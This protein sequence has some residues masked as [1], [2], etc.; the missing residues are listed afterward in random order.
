M[1]KEVLLEINRFRQISGLINESK[2][3]GVGFVVDLLDESPTIFRGLTNDQLNASLESLRLRFPDNKVI[4]SMTPETF[5]N[6]WKGLDN[7]MKSFIVKGLLDEGI[8]VID[9]LVVKSIGDIIKLEPRQIRYKMFDYEKFTDFMNY[10]EDKGIEIGDTTV[11]NSLERTFLSLRKTKVLSKQEYKMLLKQIENYNPMKFIGDVRDAFR[12]TRDV[13]ETRIIKLSNEFQ[14]KVRTNPGMKPEQLEELQ[15]V[16]SAA[17]SRELNKIEIMANEAAA[18]VFLK[19]DIDPKLKDIIENSP[20][21]FFEDFRKLRDADI[22]NIGVAINE[23]FSKFGKAINPFTR[24]TNG[25]LRLKLPKEVSSDFIQFFSTGQWAKFS[26]VYRY[27]VKTSAAESG[28]KKATYYATLLINSYKG[29]FMAHAAYIMLFTLI[30]FLR[31]KEAI[32]SF[33]VAIGQKPPYDI[34]SLAGQ[35][36]VQMDDFLSILWRNFK[37]VNGLEFAIP[38]VGTFEKSP[39]ALILKAVRGDDTNLL[40]PDVQDLIGYDPEME[41][42]FQDVFNDAEQTQLQYTLEGVKNAAAEELRPYFWQNED[43]EILY[44]GYNKKKKVTDYLITLE[45]G[46]YYVDLGTSKIKVSEI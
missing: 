41:E 5:R 42:E 25:K 40:F 17:I 12:G 31:V 14:S 32:N 45:D 10:L 16:Y 35:G 7:S 30:E 28:A 6:S 43:G 4:R 39:L 8:P 20:E 18:E 27:A 34:E 15:K 33:M 3:P 1:K 19:L 2:I 9:D 21:E 36:I 23:I 38:Y 44:R 11:I 22:S 46:E 24:N 26:D 29:H 13:I 37:D